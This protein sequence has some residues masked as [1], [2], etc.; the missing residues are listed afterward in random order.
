MGVS[1]ILCV[2]AFATVL[3]VEG[4]NA[5]PYEKLQEALEETSLVVEELR[6]EGIE[7]ALI[8]ILFKY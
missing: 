5:P 6:R 7:R 3:L 1:T 4:R 2:F 8:F